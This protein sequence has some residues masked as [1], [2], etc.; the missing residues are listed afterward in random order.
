M[1]ISRVVFTNTFFQLLGK[2]LSG[3]VAFITSIL[4]AS[5]LGIEGY[6][7]F[8]KVTT[9]VSLFWLISDF[10]L[11]AIYLK[12]DNTR[13]NELFGDVFWLRIKGAL[14]LILVAIGCLAVLPQ[15][16]YGGYTQQVKTGIAIFLITVFFQTITT[17][18]NALFQKTL[19][20]KYS[21][22]ASFLGSFISFVAVLYA[23]TLP[24]S[25]RLMASL[26]ALLLGSYVTSVA[27]WFIAK[28]K[29]KFQLKNNISGQKKIFLLTLP[30]GITLLFNVAYF[31]IDSILLTL[32]RP[33]WEVGAYGFAYKIFEFILVFPTFFMNSFFPILLQYYDQNKKHELSVLIKK[34]MIGL[35]GLGVVSALS[36]YIAAPLVSYVKPEFSLSILPL[37]I[38]SLSLPVFFL[39]SLTMWLMVIFSLQKILMIVYIAACSVNILLNILYIPHYG[40]FAAA[41][42]TVLTEIITLGI[43]LV[44]VYKKI[45]K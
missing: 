35:L 44:I 42:T 31:R 37:R 25:N 11:N 10:G 39:S 23:T 14:L 4:L 3:S 19:S 5:S 13:N 15:V 16:E 41:V 24:F 38:L 36:L 8:T 12:T 27:S 2:T 1:S 9:F 17:S 7:D 26:G 18:I 6:G 43:S 21:T 45:R 32:F 34:A 28:N 40:M 33:T 22:I 30:L 20:Y 29:I